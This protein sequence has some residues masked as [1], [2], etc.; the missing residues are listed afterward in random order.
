[1]KSTDLGKIKFVSALGTLGE[2]LRDEVSGFGR[3]PYSQLKSEG[4]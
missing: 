1:M 4:D 3:L 2:V